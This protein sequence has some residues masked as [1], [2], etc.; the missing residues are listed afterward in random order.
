MSGSARALLPALLALAAAA[1][2]HAAAPALVV[3]AA[4]DNVKRTS[5]PAAIANAG[6]ARAAGLRALRITAQC[7]RGQ[8]EISPDDRRRL[9]AA[10]EAAY[11]TGLTLTVAIYHYGSSQTPLTRADRRAFAGFA[12]SVVEAMPRLRRVIV[13]N[14]PNLNRFWMPQFGPE[15]ENVAAA[16]YVRLLAETYDTVKRIRPSLVV[17]GGAVSA[18]GA[19]RPR[20]KRPTHSPTTFIPDMGAAYR[21][22]GRARPL[23]DAFA[24]HPYPESSSAPVALRHPRTTTVGLADYDKLVRLLGEAFDGT[25][26]RGSTLPVVYAEF[27]IE[28]VIPPRKRRLYSGV[29]PPTTRP[30]REPR[31]GVAYRQALELAFCQPT[32][33]GFFM[34]HT[35]DEADLNRLQTGTYYVDATPKLSRAIVRSAA[36]SVMRGAV[37]SCPTRRSPVPAPPRP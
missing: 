10:G 23:M 7:G 36:S 9:R 15:G 37:P 20:G 5:V 13:G 28:S 4:E 6:L 18:R 30:V 32:V 14:E 12:A 33:V 11:R 1:P 24:F 8:T 17:I 31:Q 35:V 16:G 21:A 22:S 29:E 25:A 2:A 27:G 26:Q 3:G 19:D 34:F